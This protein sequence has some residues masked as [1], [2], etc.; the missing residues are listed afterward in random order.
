MIDDFFD[1]KEIWGYPKKTAERVPLA[2]KISTSVIR[3]LIKSH[4][5]IQIQKLK[6]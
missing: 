4:T 2:S 3:K 5:Q 6:A 1:E